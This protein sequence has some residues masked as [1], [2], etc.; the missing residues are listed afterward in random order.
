MQLNC[1]CVAIVV[2]VFVAIGGGDGAI[3]A[4]AAAVAVDYFGPDFRSSS[5]ISQAKCD[6]NS[7]YCWRWN[8]ERWKVTLYL[9]HIVL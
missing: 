2:V 4:I 6:E 9:C 5:Y 7:K 3:I 1:E 8:N